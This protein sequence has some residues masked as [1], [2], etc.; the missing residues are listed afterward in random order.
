MAQNPTPNNPR[1]AELKYKLAIHGV[2]CA[3]LDRK[4]G[5]Y[6]GQCANALYEPD[7][8]GERAIAKALGQTP[9]E[10]WPERFG[11]SGVRLIPQPPTNYR[12]RGFGESRRN[13]AIV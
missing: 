13:S 10:I 3:A 2:T 1:A 6:A 8:A 7:D 5:L 12:M 9:Q 11:R 4:N